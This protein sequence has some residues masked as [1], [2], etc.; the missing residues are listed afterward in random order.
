MKRRLV[1]AATI[2]VA[3]AA[4]SAG[5]GSSGSKSSG[6]VTL[7]FSSTAWQAPTVAANKKIVADWNAAHPNIQIQYI[8]VAADSVHDKLVTQFASNSAPDI[9]HDEAADIA[10]FAK[11][12][13]V[14]DLSSQ[15]PADLKSGI[16]QGIWDSVTMD[17]K[18]YGLPSLLQSYVVFANKSL[19]DKAGV[20]APTTSSPWT[21]QQFQAAAK[22]TTSGGTYGVGWGLKSPVS[23]VIST[24]LN[25]GGKFFY[26]TG[27][28]T[29]VQFGTAE[30]AVPQAIHNMIF[31]DKSLAPQTVGMAGTDVLPGF[32]AGKYAMIVGG[33]YLAQQM[34]QQA[35]KGFQWVML[36]LLKGDS[37]QQMADPQTYSVAAQSK[38]PKEAMEFL[39]YFLSAEH[40]AQLAQGDWLAPA[41]NQAA[42]AVLAGTKNQNG[43]DVVVDSAKSL[44][45]SPTVQLSDYPKWKDEIAKP[46]LQEYLA[47]KIDLA[48]LGKRLTDGWQ[49]ISAGG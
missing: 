27:G 10:G 1:A 16:P 28:K 37:Q 30:Q 41:S 19:L 36:P 4:M 3:A 25:F 45:A 13:Y 31:T 18:I 5:C 40:L 26:T 2:V 8:P 29:T 49:K 6:K 17:G 47:G 43:W 11:Q 38:H 48:A 39:D 44:V 46:A 12:G 32:F 20:T 24:A 9:V 14:I 22:K 34:V 15:I 7:K 21:W 33:N 35:P 42:Q 23:A